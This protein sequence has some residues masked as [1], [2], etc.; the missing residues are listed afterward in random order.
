M[1]WLYGRRLICFDTESATEVGGGRQQINNEEFQEENIPIHSCIN[2]Y[3]LGLFVVKKHEVRMYDLEG[4]LLANLHNN[5]F[6]DEDANNKPEI[7]L[8]R[9]D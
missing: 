6:P 5:I 1:F 4:G 9:I 8:F 3:L 2:R 7:T